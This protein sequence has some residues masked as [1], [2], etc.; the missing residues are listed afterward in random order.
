MIYFIQS[1]Q[2]LKVGYTSNM[3]N[4]YRKYVTENPN[5]IKLIGQCKGGFDVEKRIHKQL[6]KWKHN[7]EW[8]IFNDDVK[9]LIR[10]IIKENKDNDE[11]SKELGVKVKSQ[12]L[13]IHKF[14][15]SYVTEDDYID[16]TPELRSLISKEF[17]ITLD[18]VSKYLTKL[19]KL[20]LLTPTGV[21]YNYHSI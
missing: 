5:Q 9:L 18:V 13:E 19:K 7:R 21:L 8:F 12:H 15:S 2:Y 16:I 1:G 3:K 20:N 10:D 4:R 17:E 11:P 6:A 14:L